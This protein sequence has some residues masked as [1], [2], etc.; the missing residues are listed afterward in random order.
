MQLGYEDCAEY[1]LGSGDAATFCLDKP[2]SAE[3]AGERFQQPSWCCRIAKSPGGTAAVAHTSVA[4]MSA[5]PLASII[6]AAYNSEAFI[7]ETIASVQAQTLGDWELL[8]ADDGSTDRTA[9]IVATAAAEDS[10]IQLIRLEHNAGVAR[11]RNEALA[12]AQGRF[13]AFLDSDDLWL[14]QK[15]EHQ[16][17]FMQAQDVAVSYTAYRRIDEAG[18]R[19][20]RLISPPRRLGYRDLLQNT[21]IATLTGM[22]DTAKTGPIQMVEARRDDYILWLSLL[23]RGYLAYG[24]QEDLARYRVVRESLSRKPMRSAA[25]VWDVYRNVEKLGRVEATW[26]LLHYGTRALLKRLVF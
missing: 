7:G 5:A 3:T 1:G 9:A 23:K 14:P 19:T 11:A 26:C 8:V 4:G 15:L 13:I 21:A 2:R 10:R 25:W 6:M 22:V 24:L 16:I 18:Q 20:G 12:A 17:A